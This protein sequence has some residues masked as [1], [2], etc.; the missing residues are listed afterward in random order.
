MAS[1]TTKALRDIL[2]PIHSNIDTIKDHILK[3]G[4]SS[5]STSLFDRL[6]ESDKAL[7]DFFKLMKDR[8]SNEI[9]NNRRS[10]NESEK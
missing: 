7:H 3:N 1:F 5:F 9:V 4:L 8:D 2:L 6:Y 10:N